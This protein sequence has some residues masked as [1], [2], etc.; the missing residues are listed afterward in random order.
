MIQLLPL[1]VEKVKFL[2]QFHLH[3]QIPYNQEFLVEL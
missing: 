1:L 2:V 3:S